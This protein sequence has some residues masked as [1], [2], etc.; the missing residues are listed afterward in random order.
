MT[1]YSN[2]GAN[3][4]ASYQELPSLIHLRMLHAGGWYSVG[5]SKVWLLTPYLLSLNRTTF[6]ILLVT[7]GEGRGLRNLDTT[8]VFPYTGPNA[9]RWRE[10]GL[11]PSHRTGLRAAKIGN[12]LHV[13]DTKFLDEILTWDSASESWSVA[14]HMKT[15][16]SRHAVTEVSLAVMAHYCSISKSN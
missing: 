16:R 11:L 5:D 7:G 12:L 6:Q 9:G 3:K 14:G 15:A 8:E 4:E 13:T 10:A 1:E 2:L